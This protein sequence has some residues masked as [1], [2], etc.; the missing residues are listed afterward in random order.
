MG[1]ADAVYGGLVLALLLARWIDIA[2]MNGMTTQAEPATRM[3]LRR[4]IVGLL[5]LSL[6][7]YAIARWLSVSGA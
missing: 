7:G 1:R 6:A 4:Y 2:W 3:H 5:G